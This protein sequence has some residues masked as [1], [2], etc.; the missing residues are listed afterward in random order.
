MPIVFPGGS[1]SPSSIGDLSSEVILKLENRETDVGRTYQWLA[2]ALY[3]LTSSSELREEFDQ[4]EASGPYFLLTRGQRE[5][6]F[7]NIINTNDYNDGTLDMRLWTDPPVNHNPLKLHMTTYQFVD[8]YTNNPGRPTGWYRFNDLFGFDLIPDNAY[9]IQIR[10]LKQY[11]ITYPLQNTQIVLPN[12]WLDVIVLIAVHKGFIELNEYEKAESTWKILHG[13]QRQP[14][15]VGLINKRKKR[16][17]REAWRNEVLLRP[18]VGTYSY[19][20]R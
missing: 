10:Y 8:M 5:Y 16:F 4:L 3:E 1:G 11:P 12:D 9:Q 19:R 2:E 13:D 20:T 7:S 18:W 14:G 6:A 15:H 17:Q